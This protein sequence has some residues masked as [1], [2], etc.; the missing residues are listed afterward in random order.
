MGWEKLHKLKSGEQIFIDGAGNLGIEKD[1]R[2][3]VE[4]EAE[5]YAE[6]IEQWPGYELT[7]VPESKRAAFAMVV[8][9]DLRKELA[10][11]DALVTALMDDLSE[12]DI[13]MKMYK[14]RLI[15]LVRDW[16]E[17]HT[18]EKEA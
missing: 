14:N 7:K 9:R 15:M 4:L 1:H 11:R 17:P 12:A 10:N 3:L 5:N 2:D 16:D 18:K 6:I 13:Q 8:I